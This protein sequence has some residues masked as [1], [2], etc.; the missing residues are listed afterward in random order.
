[1]E[2]HAVN[3]LART[4]A[5]VLCTGFLL[6]TAPAARAQDAGARST[7]PAPAAPNIWYAVTVG[8]AGVRLTCDA[9]QAARDVGPQFSVSSGAHANPRLRVGVELGRWSY[10]EDAVRETVT[11]LG[12]VSHVKVG[13]DPRR[14][15]YLLGGIGWSGYRAGEFSYDA[16]R[17]TVGAGYDLPFVGR[18]VIGNVLALDAAA[19]APIKDE[20]VVAMRDVGLSSVRFSLQLRRQ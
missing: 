15:I 6:A 7:A 5:T 3:H 2:L 1:V 11:S 17:L 12:V 13:P 19:F 14:G 10:E 8:G 16:A 20:D 9:C 4:A 18:W